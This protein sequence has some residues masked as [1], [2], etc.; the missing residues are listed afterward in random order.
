[1]TVRELKALKIGTVIYIPGHHDVYQVLFNGGKEMRVR[2]LT[3]GYTTREKHKHYNKT[4]EVYTDS[5]VVSLPTDNYP[6][7]EVANV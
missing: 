7:K 3:S 5:M 2:S 4:L 1:M 6:F